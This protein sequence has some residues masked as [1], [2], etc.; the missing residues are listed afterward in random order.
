MQS[1]DKFAHYEP[2]LNSDCP[3]LTLWK[4]V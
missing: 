1:L 3:Y 2:K 4:S